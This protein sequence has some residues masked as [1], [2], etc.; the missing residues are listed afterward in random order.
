MNASLGGRSTALHAVC[1]GTGTLI[2]VLASAVPPFG[3]HPAAVF[4]C[5]PESQAEN[6]YELTGLPIPDQA[7][8]TALIVEGLGA[9]APSVY[10]VS[11]EQFAPEATPSPS[12]W[13]AAVVVAFRPSGAGVGPPI[14]PWRRDS[15]A[16]RLTLRPPR[17]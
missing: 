13:L 6:R 2:V 9:T 8:V 14:L 16:A 17:P 12:S 3:A 1:V 5:G 11:V 10:F 7:F 4:Q 15:D